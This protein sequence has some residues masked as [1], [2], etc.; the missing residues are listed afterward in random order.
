[1]LQFCFKKK[2]TELKLNHNEIFLHKKLF[3]KKQEIDEKNYKWITE[4]IF[5]VLLFNFLYGNLKII[6]IIRLS[7]AHRSG[8]FTSRL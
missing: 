6:V 1:M 3:L 4:N 8:I 5:A 2:L 7:A